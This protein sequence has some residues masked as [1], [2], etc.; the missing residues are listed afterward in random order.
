M[1]AL[2]VLVLLAGPLAARA[3]GGTDP[4]AEAK[5]QFEAGVV[6]LKAENYEGAALSFEASLE[7]FATKTAMFNLANCYKALDRYEE[8]LSL[9]SRMR[10]EFS[11]SL[12][13]EMSATISAIEKEIDKIVSKLKVEVDRAGAKV[14]V[15]G[16]EVGTSPLGRPLLVVAGSHEITA[17]LEGFEFGVEK[18]RLLSGT[19]L[20]VR[21]TG[22]KK[23]APPP[24][25]E[26]PEPLPASPGQDAAG[27]A[28]EGDGLH[29]GWFWGSLAA[30]AALG[31]ATIGMAVAVDKA[32]SDVQD[33]AEKDSVE[34]MQAGGIAL[35]ALTGAAALT[36]AVLGFFT[37]W[38]GVGEEEP[39]GASPSRSS[40]DSASSRPIPAAWATDNGAGIAFSGRF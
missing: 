27:S 24:A 29:T 11:G 8:A 35:M 10:R 33:Q 16:R 37:D 5:R 28:L 3:A 7:L 40:S 25:T 6:L 19:E 15:N 12:D 34:R 36:A 30:T 17:R 39:A 13:D 20:A 1:R 26:R 32:K 18:V 14:L 31:G 4:K 38:K 2:V 21:L 9:L 22:R 23:V